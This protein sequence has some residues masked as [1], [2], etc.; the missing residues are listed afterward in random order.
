M[1]GW[2]AWVGLDWVNLAKKVLRRSAKKERKE[3]VDEESWQERSRGDR[4]GNLGSYFDASSGAEHQSSTVLVAAE[5]CQGRAG[6][7]SKNTLFREGGIWWRHSI[8]H[9]ILWIAKN[10]E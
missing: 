10:Q 7:G 5:F 4:E 9:R 2:V 8:Q 3:R 6:P 1:S